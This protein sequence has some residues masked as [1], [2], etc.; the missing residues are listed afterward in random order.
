METVPSGHLGGEAVLG[1]AVQRT[2]IAP[3]TPGTIR[4]APLAS[5]KSVSAHI[6]FH[7]T[8][9]LGRWIGIV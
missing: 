7:T 6:E 5:V 4:V 8:G 2:M 1:F 9:R 3:V